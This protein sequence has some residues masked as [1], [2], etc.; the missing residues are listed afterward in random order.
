MKTRARLILLC[1][2]LLLGA[3]FSGQYYR[4]IK[5]GVNVRLDSSP[6]SEVS[7]NLKK[8]E[9]VEVLE[10]RYDWYKIRLP[11]RFSCYV[12]AEFI[13][14]IGP[15]KVKVNASLLNMRKD[16]SLDSYVI[17]KAKRGDILNIVGKKDGWYK[18]SGYP[19]AFGWAHKDFFKRVL[20]R[21]VSQEGVILYFKQRNC[22]ANCLLKNDKKYPLKIVSRRNQKFINKRVRIIAKKM[23]DGCDYLL[24]K[25]LCFKR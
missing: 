25:K 5:D 22:E 1:L 17:G 7:G 24:V 13:Q 16:P 6:M 20:E 23:T 21:Y 3:G 15:G 14:E 12:S 8:N 19:Y 2:P 10:E 11:K 9:L 4:A 18:V